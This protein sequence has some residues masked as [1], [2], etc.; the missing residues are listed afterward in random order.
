MEILSKLIVDAEWHGFEIAS[1]AD[2]RW[3]AIPMLYN[4]RLVE[5]P[6]GSFEYMHGWCFRSMP[7]LLAAAVLWDPRTVNEP[8]GWHKRATHPPR[9]APAAAECPFPSMNDP[10]CV[11]GTYLSAGRCTVAD[12]CPDFLRAS[13]S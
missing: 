5:L 7:M 9:V 3:L 13:R 2:T 10:R 8:G 6:R 1:D 4:H 11:H 12:V